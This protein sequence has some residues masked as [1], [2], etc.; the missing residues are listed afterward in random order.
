MQSGET[1]IYINV[2]AVDYANKTYY[3]QLYKAL[4]S[5]TVLSSDIESNTYSILALLAMSKCPISV[6][7]VLCWTYS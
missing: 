1:T 2:I 3:Y 5:V 6:L 4:F 7:Y